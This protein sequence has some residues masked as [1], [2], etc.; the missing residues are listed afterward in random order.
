MKLIY[1]SKENGD[2]TVFFYNTA[3]LHMIMIVLR[4]PTRKSSSHGE[5]GFFYS[6]AKGLNMSSTEKN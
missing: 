5:A 4:V 1:S 3:D 2:V 6:T